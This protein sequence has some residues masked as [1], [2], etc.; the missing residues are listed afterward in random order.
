MYVKKT[1]SPT[2]GKQVYIDGK[3]FRSLF[4]ASVDTGLTYWLISQ[5]LAA[6]GG[7]PCYIKKHEIVLEKWLLD[8]PS[9]ILESEGA[10]NDTI[11]RT[12]VSI[13]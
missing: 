12:S 11:R 5:K 7:A 1:D 2:N 8:N 4:Q 9:K 3:R 10:P 13:A 6:S